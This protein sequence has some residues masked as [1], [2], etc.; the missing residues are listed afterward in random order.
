MEPTADSTSSTEAGRRRVAVGRV[1]GAHG[2]R[3]LIRVRYFTDDASDLEQLR[4]V[5]LAD[6]E[7]DGEQLGFRVEAVRPGRSG[8]V[9]MTLAGVRRREAAE[10]LRGRLVWV[11]TEQL[12]PAEDGEHWGFELVGCRVED[13]EGHPVGRVR[14]IGSNGA[15]AL[16]V[17]E[18]EDGVEHLIPAVR[19][20]MPEVDVAARRIVIEVAPGL[21]EPRA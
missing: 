9:R 13:T 3:G 11:D 21:L 7:G 14:D 4:D 20:W 2:L 8:E 19:E 12:G 6:E 10:A 18:T 1:A 5:L 15:Q 16:L 17:V